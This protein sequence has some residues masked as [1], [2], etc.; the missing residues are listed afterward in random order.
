MQKGLLIR[1]AVGYSRVLFKV[2][3]HH[4]FYPSMSGTTLNLSVFLAEE[5]WL[6]SRPEENA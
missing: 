3:L 1:E 4:M 5:V 2:K 6:E